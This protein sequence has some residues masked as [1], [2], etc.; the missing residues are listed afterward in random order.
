MIRDHE[1][2]KMEEVERRKKEFRE[3]WKFQTVE[4]AS[5]HLQRF[6]TIARPPTQFSSATMTPSG[7]SSTEKDTNQVHIQCICKFDLQ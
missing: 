2:K 4:N 5:E 3:K 7:F 1:K 6:A